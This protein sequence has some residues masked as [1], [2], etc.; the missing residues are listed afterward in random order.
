MAADADAR[1]GSGTDVAAPI[2]PSTVLT[3][4]LLFHNERVAQRRHR[5]VC[6]ARGR[7]HAHR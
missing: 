1:F 7:A 4:H 2:F 6:G 3:L 5:I